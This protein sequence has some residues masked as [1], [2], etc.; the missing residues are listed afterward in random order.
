MTN[1]P[2]PY[3]HLAAGS[4]YDGQAGRPSRLR[5]LARESASVPQLAWGGNFDL[6]TAARW[7]RPRPHR[8]LP[9]KAASASWLS[10]GGDLAFALRLAEED[11]STPPLAVEGRLC[12][13]TSRER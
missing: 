4:G 3:L 10:G 7:G 13:A 12:V 1:E 6:R 9:W 2:H 8:R 5:S 11:S